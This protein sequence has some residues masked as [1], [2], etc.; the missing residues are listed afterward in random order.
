VEFAG[1]RAQGK[2]PG[3]AVASGLHESPAVLLISHVLTELGDEQMNALSD[4]AA[5]AACVLWVEPGT[6]ECSRRLIAV[7]ERLRDKLQ[8]IAPCPHQA[9][10][11]MRAP[12]NEAHWC[13]H[14]AAPPAAVFTDPD[15]GRF[16]HETG[17]DL[18]S[19]PVSFLV[20][21]RRPAPVPPP[22]AARVIGRPRVYKAHAAVLACEAAGVRELRLS[23][24]ALPEAFRRIKK[25]D[26]PPLQTWQTDGDEITGTADW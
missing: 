18:R 26:F 13:H 8:V 22:G 24:R 12:G 25:D 16:A 23:K 20:L 7:R 10:C 1:K 5:R 6:H 3:L 19:L 11:G 14:F 21:D 9:P 2:Y 15:W 17:I 4:L